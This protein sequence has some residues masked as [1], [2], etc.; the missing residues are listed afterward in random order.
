MRDVREFSGSYN[1]CPQGVSHRA[2]TRMR[3][4]GTEGL[5]S[6]QL[7]PESAY[8]LQFRALSA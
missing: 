6:A 4:G 3:P 7:V 1:L 2:R 5:A 8:L